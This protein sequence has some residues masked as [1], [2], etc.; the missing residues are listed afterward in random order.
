[1]TLIATFPKM[2]TYENKPEKCGVFFSADLRSF[3]DHVSPAFH[4]ALSIKK[5]C[6]AHHISQKPLQN[7]HSTTPEKK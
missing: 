1:M 3:S 4:H 5:P 2:G 6:S 7:T